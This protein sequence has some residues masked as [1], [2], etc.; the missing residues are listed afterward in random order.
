[1]HSCH[2]TPFQLKKTCKKTCQENIDFIQSKRN[3]G[4]RTVTR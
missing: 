3:K 4:K 2:N 1:M